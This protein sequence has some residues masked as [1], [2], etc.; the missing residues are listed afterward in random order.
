MRIFYE[1]KIVKQSFRKNK[2]LNMILIISLTIALTIMSILFGFLN[3]NYNNVK[4]QIKLEKEQINVSL[5][6]PVGINEL[7]A[8][9]KQWNNIGIKRWTYL[10]S[11]DDL[12]QTKEISEMLPIFGAN[13]HFQLQD[14]K[15]PVNKLES[16][17]VVLS[18]KAANILFPKE[19]EDKIIGKTINISG[20]SFQIVSLWEKSLVENIYISI[21]DFMDLYGEKTDVIIGSFLFEKLAEK[22][23]EKEIMSSLEA[24]SPTVIDDISESSMQRFYILLFSLMIIAIILMVYVIL[25]NAYLFIYKIRKDQQKWR[26][27]FY[28]GAT[29]RILRKVIY[30]ESICILLIASIVSM[31]LTFFSMKMIKIDGLSF[32]FDFLVVLFVFLAMIIIIVFTVETAIKEIM[33]STIKENNV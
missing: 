23:I 2:M 6:S 27:L 4:G 25:N 29:S 26:T 20:T 12:V 16:R 15:F 28:L 13:E 24:Y 5:I 11:K 30:L 1:L 7:S 32:D 17:T 18:V 9:E 10:V 14:A 22:Q 33:R 19:S 21:E 3:T 31:Q 8:L